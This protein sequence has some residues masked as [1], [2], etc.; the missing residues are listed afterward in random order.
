MRRI[1]YFNLNYE[2]DELDEFCHADRKG[3]TQSAYCTANFTNPCGEVL[4]TN[5]HEHPAWIR[6][7]RCRLR[8]RAI[9]LI[10][11]AWQNS[12]NSSNS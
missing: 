1:I 7:I 2:F 5:L 12:S 4:F 8:L 6:V 11:S 3:I 9:V 10:L